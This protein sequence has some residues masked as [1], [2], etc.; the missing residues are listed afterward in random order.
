MIQQ[1]VDL[2]DAQ[3]EQE[4]NLRALEEKVDRNL[5][6]TGFFTIVAYG[7]MSGTRVPSSV[8]NM[9]GKRAASISRQRGIIIGKAPDEKWGEVGAYRKDILEEVFEN[10]LANG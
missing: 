9:L 6:G 5:G 2:E 10:Y 3:E 4:A 7:K 8:A 1:L